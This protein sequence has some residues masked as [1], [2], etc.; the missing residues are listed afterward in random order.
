MSSLRTSRFGRASVDN[1]YEQILIPSDGSRGVET[2]VLHGVSLALEYGATIH[3]IHVVEMNGE[4]GES[5]SHRF[6]RGDE[7][8]AA[9]AVEP[10]LHRA[11]ATGLNVIPAVERGRPVEVIRNYAIENDIDLIV[12]GTHKRT[13]LARF[14]QHSV[15]EQMLEDAPVPVLVVGKNHAPDTE[16]DTST[17]RYSDVLV[18]TDGCE[19]ASVALEH[20]LEVARRFGATLHG[21]FVVDQRAYMTKPGFTWDEAIDSW[22]VRG[23]GVLADVVERAAAFDLDVRTTLAHG[24]PPKET[25]EYVTE[26]D[27]DFVV[28]GTRELAGVSR[29]LWGSV[30]TRV[31]RDAN[32]PVLS[33]N[34]VI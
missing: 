32:V 25:L 5:A 9:A 13:G 3:T 31:V 18:A 26:N 1:S 11:H 28:L 19:R 2:A 21:L 15:V 27:V 8:D 14:L 16:E 20:G 22:N 30:A 10:V 24:R 33:V 6:S 7:W 34:R 4:H 29:L 23:K 12:L 17:R